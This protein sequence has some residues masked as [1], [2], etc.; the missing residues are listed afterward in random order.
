MAC[1][2]F[3]DEAKMNPNPFYPDSP[4]EEDEATNEGMM[5]SDEKGQEDE[6]KE[7]SFMKMMDRKTDTK[8]EEYK[9]PQLIPEEYWIY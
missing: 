1:S 6:T 7:E 3:L 8:E 9:G 2:G 5:P 4:Y